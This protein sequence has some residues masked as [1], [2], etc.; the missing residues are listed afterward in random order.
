DDHQLDELKK[1]IARSFRVLPERSWIRRL[2]EAV[3][4]AA[5]GTSGDAP[6]R[7]EA[8]LV[9]TLRAQGPGVAHKTVTPE[10]G[11]PA[12]WRALRFV[13][14]AKASH[15]TPP[16]TSAPGRIRPALCRLFHRSE[17]APMTC[18][19]HK[20]PNRWIMKIAMAI[21]LALRFTGTDSRI[22]VLTGPVERNRKKTVVA[23]EAIQTVTFVVRNVAKAGTTAASVE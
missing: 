19:D 20:S 6:L 2:A 7:D 17:R 4:E 21:A 14:K 16:I 13:F 8:D 12:T 18:E 22:S 15:N 11:A 1:W 9:F 10:F 3:M 5:H 23:S